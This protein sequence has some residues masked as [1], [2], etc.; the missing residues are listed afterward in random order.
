MSPSK[1]TVDV[2]PV[3]EA[4]QADENEDYVLFYQP[5]DAEVQRISGSLYV[6]ADGLGGGA[7]GKTASRYAAHKVVSDYY[8]SSEPD[9]GLRLRE[10]IAAANTDLRAY[11]AQ[12]PELVKVGTTLVALVIRGEQ[13]HIASVGDSRAYLV[14]DGGIQQIT[15]D[16][17]LVQQL[18]DEGAIGPEEAHDH[19]RRDVVLRSLGAADEVLVDVYDLRMRPDDS[20]ILCTDGLTRY[21]YD[22]EIAEIAASASPRSTAETLVKK[23]LDHGGKDNVT[24]LAALLRDGAPSSTAGIPHAW[25]GAPATFDEQPTLATPRPRLPEEPA[26]TGDKTIRAAR[27]EQPGE[28]MVSPAAAALPPAADR[29]GPPAPVQPASAGA[30]IDPETG[31]PPIPVG[32]TEQPA[33]PAGYHPRVY[34]SQTQPA[35]RRE[36][37]GVSVGAFAAV[38]VFAVLLT[39]LMVLVLLNPFGWNLPGRGGEAAAVTTE[40]APSE[41]AAAQPTATSAPAAAETTEPATPAPTATPTLEVAPAPAGMVLVPGGSFI[42]GVSDEEAE[43][44]TLACINE[45][46]EENNILCYPEYFGDAQP[47]EEVTLSPF[48]IDIT[49]VTNL[50]YGNCV[51]AGACTAPDNTEFYADPAY[52]QHPVVYI[53]YDQATQYC[54]WAGKRLPTEAEWEKA[55]RWDPDTSQSYWYPWGNDW[56]DGR[57]NTAAA[58]LGGLS[59]VQA[60]SRDL[61]PMG[62]LGMAGNASEWVQDW[63]FDSYTG[64]GTLNPVRLGTQPLL[65]P[66]R[67]ARGGNFESLSPFARSGHRYDVPP[68]SGASWVGFRCAASV[69]GEETPAPE[70]TPA[71]GEAAPEGETTPE[72][73]ATPTP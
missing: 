61:S 18:I 62:V 1:L 44:A 65:E 50:A 21:L 46:T 69:A 55:A 35:L 64:L 30:M 31:L 24:V 68:D 73:E 58:G 60:F 9:L 45:T 49:E 26:P 23:A 32:G 41:Q 5:A 16:H 39:I 27:V 71:E 7:R 63:Y 67:V 47:V 28:G 54:E 10:A 40:A 53:T 56:E 29:P 8:S 34:R 66:F 36:R 72:V 11:A 6:V 52:A 38:G 57:A 51:T 59:A 42:R 4:G 14:R 25:D 43:A 37:R 19:P 48:Y 13:V 20:I 12:R 15:R 3:T 17:T 70:A 22:E 33:A 2:W